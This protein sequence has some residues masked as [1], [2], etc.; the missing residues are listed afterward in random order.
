[1]VNLPTWIRIRIQPS[2]IHADPAL[3]LST[4]SLQLFHTT[5]LLLTTF[6]AYYFQSSTISFL[7]SLFHIK[8]P[9][10]IFP[11]RLQLISILIVQ[12]FSWFPNSSKIIVCPLHSSL[13]YIF[14]PPPT[15]HLLYILSIYLCFLCSLL[16][17]LPFFFMY[18]SPPPS[19]HYCVQ[20][21]YI[22]RS[23]E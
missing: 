6:Y 4:Y 19:G 20:C 23:V 10:R 18:I 2:I 7:L 5:P 9:L 16:S 22:R 3:L 8:G 15:W 21:M 1:M 14:P 12:S 13:Q 17:S 11:T